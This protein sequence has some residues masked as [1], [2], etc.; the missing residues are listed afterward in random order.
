MDLA[1]FCRFNFFFVLPFGGL[2][3][4]DEALFCTVF[5]IGNQNIKKQCYEN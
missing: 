3:I 1:D 2:I 4:F 5:A